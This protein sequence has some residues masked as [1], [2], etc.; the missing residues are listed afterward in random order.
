[1]NLR[2]LQTKVQMKDSQLDIANVNLRSLKK[3]LQMKDSQLLTN[4][5]ELLK[6]SGYSMVVQGK[7]LTF[8]R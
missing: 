7:N 1:M 6:T 3:T 8:E 5:F 2:P 4:A